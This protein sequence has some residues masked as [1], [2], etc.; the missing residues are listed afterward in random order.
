M[1]HWTPTPAMLGY[2][3]LNGTETEVVE[4]MGAMILVLAMEDCRITTEAVSYRMA[5][6]ATRAR[7]L[8]SFIII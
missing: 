4:K 8:I 1:I 5:R 6:K 2:A 3:V 7:F